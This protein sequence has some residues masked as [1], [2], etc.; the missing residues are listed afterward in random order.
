KIK[1]RAEAAIQRTTKTKSRNATAAA[2]R[3]A[4]QATRPGCRAE[5]AI[6]RRKPKAENPR[7]PQAPPG[8]SRST[9]P[10]KKAYKKKLRKIKR[11]GALSGFAL[12]F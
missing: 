7:P 12:A 6:Q 11:F 8:R 9:G 2:G 1:C 5:A 4:G 3:P 10:N